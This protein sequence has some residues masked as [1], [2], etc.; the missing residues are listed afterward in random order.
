MACRYLRNPKASLTALHLAKA[1][2]DD[3]EC[4]E[5]MQAI[6]SNSRLTALDLS[7]NLIGC[8]MILIDSMYQAVLLSNLSSHLSTSSPLTPRLTARNLSNTNSLGARP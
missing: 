8:A 7:N 1:D 4:A 2:V 5:F 6:A 3:D